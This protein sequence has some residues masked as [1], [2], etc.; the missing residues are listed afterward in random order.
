MAT[1]NSWSLTRSRP[2]ATTDRVGT[3]TGSAL[4]GPRRCIPLAFVR[5]LGTGRHVP[6]AVSAPGGQNWSSLV[7][8]D[9][10][11]TPLETSA[12]PAPRRRRA[13]HLIAIDT[14]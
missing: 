11:T 10:P 13:G 14:P 3:C 8:D 2:I 12:T 5:R 9:T 4:A 1:R 7:S 6:R